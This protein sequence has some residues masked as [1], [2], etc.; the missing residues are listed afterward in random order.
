MPSGEPCPRG[1]REKRRKRRPCQALKFPLL[2]KDGGGLGNLPGPHNLSSVSLK[3][4]KEPFL[5]FQSYG[6]IPDK[7][8]EA[9]LGEVY[10]SNGLRRETP[11]LKE[12]VSSMEEVCVRVCSV[13]Q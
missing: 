7:E 12:L 5:L 8:I 3:S 4:Q 9:R 10:F 6:H 11:F 2:E 1:Q 13:A